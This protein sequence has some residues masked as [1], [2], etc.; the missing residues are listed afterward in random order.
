MDGFL[1]GLVAG[2]VAPFVGMFIARISRGRTLRELVF[3]VLLAPTLFSFVWIGLFGGTALHG[4]LY[5]T[6]GIAAAVSA[7]VTLALYRT[8]DL[9]GSTGLSTAAAAVATLLIATYFI[10]SADSGTLVINTILAGGDPD[11]PLL[12]RVLWGIGVGILTGILLAGGGVPTLQSAVV[13][14]GLPFSVVVLVMVLGLVTALHREEYGPRPARKS[15]LSREPWT[16]RDRLGRATKD[17]TSAGNTR[18]RAIP[19]R[20]GRPG[21]RA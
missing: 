21:G 14:A 19:S 1:L 3:G 7:D 16:G 8:I 13:M 2:L 17:K 6:G 9:M 5:G 20:G 18:F 4:E 15:R 10:T 11:P 12:P